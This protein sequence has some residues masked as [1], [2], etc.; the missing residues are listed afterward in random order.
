MVIH[1]NL[2]LK[3]SE[4][5]K[6]LKF[7]KITNIF[8]NNKRKMINKNIKKILKKDEIIRIKNIKLDM[9]PADIEPNIYYKITELIENR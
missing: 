1:L 3:S 8:F 5:Y 9:R 6:I 7:R 4:I 2:K